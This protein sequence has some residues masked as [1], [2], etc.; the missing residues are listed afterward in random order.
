MAVEACKA[1][2]KVKITYPGAKPRSEEVEVKPS[3]GKNNGHWYCVTHQE[4]FQNNFM[5]DTHIR[6]GKHRL[7]WI[8]HEHGAEEP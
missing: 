1:G 8:C 4:G 6:N 2:E 7:A 3:C 5:K